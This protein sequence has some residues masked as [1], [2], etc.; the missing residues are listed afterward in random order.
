MVVPVQISQFKFYS[1]P[2]VLSIFLKFWYFREE[3]VFDVARRVDA[4]I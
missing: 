4:A 1:Y 2:L 3:D